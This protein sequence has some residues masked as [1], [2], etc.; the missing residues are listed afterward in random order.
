M[1]PVDEDADAGDDEAS[2]ETLDTVRLDGLDID[3]DHAVEF[4]FLAL[5]LSVIG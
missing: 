3:I 1:L 5:G 2:V 4:A